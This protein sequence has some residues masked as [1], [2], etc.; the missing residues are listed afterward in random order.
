MVETIL[1]ATTR[2]LKERGYEALTT[3]YVAERAGISIG[4][5]YQYFP[6]KVSLL[7]ALNAAHSADM[8]A[9]IASVIS[10]NQSQGLLFD[11]TALIRAAMAAHEHDPEMHQILEKELPVFEEVEPVG[12]GIFRHIE[13][14]IRRNT[15]EINR[16]CDTE[17]T[18]WMVMRLTRSLV[19][20]AILEAPPGKA[21][22]EVEAEIVSC[23]Y[24]YL[25]G[26][27]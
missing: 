27:D 21:A 18:A 26:A 24:L 11:I 14:L 8:A 1:D 4:S 17:M 15:S 13:E 6:D 10:D 16:T 5:L 20:S 12:G 9:A 25:H 19:H 23:I 2:V 22:S 7:E 3:N